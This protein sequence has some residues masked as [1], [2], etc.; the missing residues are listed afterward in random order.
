MKA[1]MLTTSFPRHAGDF[2]G[3][4]I[5]ALADEIAKKGHS[6]WVVV[7]GDP[8]VPRYEKMRGVEVH[9]FFYMIPPSLQRLTQDSGIPTNLRKSFLAKLQIPPFLLV[10][11]IKGLIRSLNSDIIHA[12]W[13]A[14]GFI[15]GIIKTLSG[16]PLVIT[17]HGSEIYLVHS[18]IGKKIALSILKRADLITAASKD[19]LSKLTEWGIDIRKTQF[20]PL[21]V[22]TKIFLPKG[23][24]NLKIRPGFMSNV[25]Y[26]LFVGRLVPI[27]GVEYL[28]RAVPAVIKRFKRVRFFI[29]GDGDSMRSLEN[30]SEKLKISAYINF[31]GRQPRNKVAEYMNASDIFVLPSLSEGRSVTVLEAMACGLPVIAT[32]VGGVPE[33]ILDSVTGYLVPPRKP[34]ALSDK[35]LFLLENPSHCKAMGRS[36]KRRL[37]EL[38]L[39]WENAATRTIEIYQDIL[40]QSL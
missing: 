31:V 33:S 32:R 17:V 24:G 39:T 10:F 16:K 23:S 26:V 28:I 25:K 20:V 19:L 36:G 37:G 2:S 22:D 29:V 7:P 40:N 3:N 35:I 15:G 6:V 9:R 11:L 14:A 38:G 21:G 30:L 5:L 12:H 27:K 4:F 13:T 18:K 1:C 34:R 8:G